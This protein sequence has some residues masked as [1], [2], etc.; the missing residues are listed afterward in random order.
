MPRIVERPKARKELEDI[1]V[2]IGRH[3][4]SAASRF[5]AVVQKL[6]GSLATMPE[7]G[8][9]WEPENPHFAGVRYFAISR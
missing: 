4:P 2:Y 6:Y 7:M 3:R 1:A 5:L 8:S 9:L